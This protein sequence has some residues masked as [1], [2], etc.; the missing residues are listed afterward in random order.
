MRAT[1]SGKHEWDGLWTARNKNETWSMMCGLKE[2]IW[3]MIDEVD[4]VTHRNYSEVHMVTF[5]R[6]FISETKEQE[7]NLFTVSVFISAANNFIFGT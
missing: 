6:C 4:N 3:N 7:G 1:K 2:M 5:Q